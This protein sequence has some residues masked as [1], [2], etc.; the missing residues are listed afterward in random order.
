MPY[1]LKMLILSLAEA[2]ISLEYTTTQSCSRDLRTSVMS[3][4]NV[5]GVF[6]MPNGTTI[7]L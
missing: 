1:A 2:K 3:H 4:I 5:E 6:D 7:H